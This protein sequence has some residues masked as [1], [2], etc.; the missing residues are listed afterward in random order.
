MPQLSRADEADAAA[1]TIRAIHLG[2]AI[3]TTT[4]LYPLSFSVPRSHTLAVLGPS[5][6]GKSTLLRLLNRLDEPTSGTV[7]L[8]GVDYR[9]LPPAELRRRVGMVM[10]RAYLF[11]GTVRE[12]IL[13]GPAQRERAPATDV[14]ALLRRVGI[15]GYSGRAVHTLSGGEAQR[16]AIARAL[17]NEPEVLLLDEPTSALD[18]KSKRA[19]EQ[20]LESIIQ[21]RGLSCV[22]VTHDPLQAARMANTVLMLKG[23]RMDAFGEAR[24]ILAEQAAIAALP[25]GEAADA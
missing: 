11:P 6:S 21:E 14:D 15:D 3:S 23:G 20:L 10:Q 12:N 17:A 4:L 2:R 18:E 8:D 16:V 13:F 5:G 22:W 9:T 24:E 25:T 1:T 7:E 19:I